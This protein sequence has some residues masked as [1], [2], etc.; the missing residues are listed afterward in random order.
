M[1][2]VCFFVSL[3]VCTTCFYSNWSLDLVK[4]LNLPEKLNI[5]YHEKS[6]HQKSSIFLVFFHCVR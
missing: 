3:L 6:L 5:L 1:T 2:Y 4:N